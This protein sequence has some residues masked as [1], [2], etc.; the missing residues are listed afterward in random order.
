[1]LSPFYFYGAAVTVLS[2]LGSHVAATDANCCFTPSQAHSRQISDNYLALGNG[3]YSLLDATFMPD[4]EVLSGRF[5]SPPGYGDGSIQREIHT[6]KEFLEFIKLS[7]E[8]WDNYRFEVDRWAANDYEIAIRWRIN[9]VMG[10]NF[11][12]F[13]TT[14]KQGDF[15]TWNGTH[16]LE[17]D[18]CTGLIKQ[19]DSSEDF[20]TMLYNLGIKS[21][22]I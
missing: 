11:T 9:A 16:F 7:R 15:S 3:D 19:V 18:A 4:L 14:L 8:G 2:I 20:I 21:V 5:P 12:T 1:M 17:L 10:A 22:L 13:P 6:S